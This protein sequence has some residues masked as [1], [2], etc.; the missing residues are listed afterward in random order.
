MSNVENSEK[1]YRHAAVA[2]MGAFAG[3]SAV[4]AGSHPTH[5][6]NLDGTN[7]FA[8][9]SADKYGGAS[10]SGA[11][12]DI[13]GDGIDDV[14][15]GSPV[16]DVDDGM[17]GTIE[18]AGSTFVV[19]GTPGDRAPQFDL[20]AIDGTNGFRIDGELAVE[21]SGFSVASGDINGDGIDDVIIGSPGHNDPMPEMDQYSYGAVHVVFGSDS[22]IPA[23]VNVADLDGTNGFSLHGALPGDVAGTTVA[24]G[25]V[26]GDLFDDVLIGAPGVSPDDGMAGTID[27]AGS[28]YVVFG[29][30]SGIPA[31]ANLDDLNGTNG[32]AIPGLLEDDNAG[33][34]VEVADVNGD[35]FDDVIVLSNPD[36]G[37]KYDGEGWVIFG[38]GS[39]FTDTFDALSLD[40][41][42]GFV[43]DGGD[44][45]FLLDVAG[46]GDING[47]GFEDIG[48]GGFP[49]GSVLFGSDQSPFP[50]HPIDLSALDGTQG[51]YIVDDIDGPNFIGFG[52]GG[53]VN[54]DGFDDIVVSHGKYGIGDFFDSEAAVVFGHNGDFGNFFN[55]N[56]L[57]G[58]NGFNIT[59]PNDSLIVA[60]YAENLSI[61][62]DIN[63]DGF[64]DV[65][66]G[67]FTDVAE[68]GPDIGTT[69]V[70]FG[71][72]MFIPIEVPTLS[73]WGIIG[74]VTALALG[75]YHKVRKLVAAPASS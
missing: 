16:T 40:G 55:L 37:D 9:S 43:F 63:G 74:L 71:D 65:V 18:A 66:M 49:V 10:F 25:N 50:E 4:G 46:L 1:Q 70:V 2:G 68:D 33:L 36:G 29:A 22:G 12:G 48:V 62:G 30:N 44:N 73:E 72:E 21:F 35:S 11:T 69:Y 38:K 23:V 58:F 57:N 14:I 32:F 67:V 59:T 75:A 64:N 15:I 26:N 52:P 31:D 19:F 13:N 61:D 20:S 24:A 47:D 8:I 53:N 56:T 5:V 27:H 41:T 3:L 39:G 51:F 34:D 7:G 54:G 45:L 60:K 42:N 6:G 28:A 17:S